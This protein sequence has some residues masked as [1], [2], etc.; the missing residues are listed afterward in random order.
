[1]FRPVAQGSFA[2]T[3]AG[4]RGRRTEHG[5]VRRASGRHGV[6][7]LPRWRPPR[8]PT[9]H[10]LACC[11]RLCQPPRRPR[12]R[13]SSTANAPGTARAKPGAV[14]SASTVAVNVA[15]VTEV[16]VLRRRCDHAGTGLE[17]AS[18]AAAPPTGSNAVPSFPTKKRWKRTSVRIDWLPYE[19]T[20][21][22]A[23]API[24]S[25]PRCAGWE[26]VRTGGGARGVGGSGRAAVA[27]L[28][29]CA[30]RHACGFDVVAPDAVE[31]ARTVA[32]SS[33]WGYWRANAGKERRLAREEV[34]AAVQPAA[35]RPLF[36]PR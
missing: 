15:R 18:A 1:M 21:I 31:G 27:T 29:D 9:R 17:P 35:E 36:T 34:D 14:D 30:G 25:R 6:C 2:E 4:E 11:R 16:K 26:A 32:A 23:S 22:S 24:R 5:G 12:R 33:A 10:A 20:S 28:A 7:L 19:R 3:L 13:R 8:P